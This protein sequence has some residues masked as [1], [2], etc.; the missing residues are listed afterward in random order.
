VLFRS[1]ATFQ[2]TTYIYPG[3]V[4]KV[5]TDYALVKSSSYGVPNHTFTL[6]GT[7]LSAHAAGATFTQKGNSFWTGTGKVGSPS[8]FG[9]SDLFVGADG[10]HPSPAGHVALANEATRQYIMQTAPN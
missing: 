2:S 8:G 1:A 10:T 5:D 9:N 4:I 7:F 6:D 3:A